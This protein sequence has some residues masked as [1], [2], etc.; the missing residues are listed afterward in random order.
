MLIDGYEPRF[1]RDYAYGRQ[2]ELLV[3]NVLEQLAAGQGQVEVKRSRYAD[4]VVFVELQQKPRGASHYKPSGLSTT[5]A[6]YWAFVKPGGLFVLIPT[7]TLRREAA[8]RSEHGATLVNGGLT[9]DN[10]TRGLRIYLP[11][12][13]RWST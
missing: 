11:N 8:Y 13:F 7:E 4:L 2:G 9:G 3:H 1:D 5:S 12:L 10:P 6:E